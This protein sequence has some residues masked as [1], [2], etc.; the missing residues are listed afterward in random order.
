LSRSLPVRQPFCARIR[1]FFLKKT[2]K[3]LLLTEKSGII[4]YNHRNFLHT[5]D[6]MTVHNDRQLGAFGRYVHGLKRVVLSGP[7]K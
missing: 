4:I 3:Q 5:P 2:G 7:R 1:G 6:G